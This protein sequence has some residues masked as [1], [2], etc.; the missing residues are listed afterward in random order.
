M[1]PLE[2]VDL[3]LQTDD[4]GVI[5][6]GNTRVTLQTVI[7]DFHRGASPE[8]IVHHYPALMLPDVY[9][10]VGYYLQHQD[11]VDQYI[12]RQREGFEEARK[13]YEAQHIQDPL[14]VRLLTALRQSQKSS[15]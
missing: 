7:S 2:A 12:Q 4:G 6:V 9:L 8:E 5:R 1:F 11:E 10:V 13:D 14:R 3:P 15:T